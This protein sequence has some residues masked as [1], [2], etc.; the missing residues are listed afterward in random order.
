M[1]AM[2]AARRSSWWSGGKGRAGGPADDADGA[3]ELDPIRIDVGFSGGLADQR[4]NRVMSE[5][6]AVYFLA[7]HVWALERS[8]RPGP[9]RWVL[10]WSS[11][12]SCS[13]LSW[14]A[15]ASSGAGGSADRCGW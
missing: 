14:Y 13:H 2:I 9:V 4:A 12:V 10:S 1:L 5:Q 11:P 6:V 8:A 7:D 3:G 15:C